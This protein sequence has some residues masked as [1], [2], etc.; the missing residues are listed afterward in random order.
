MKIDKDL[1]RIIVEI[2]DKLGGKSR[3]QFKCEDEYYNEIARL[4]NEDISLLDASKG[5][6]FSLPL[7]NQHKAHSAHAWRMLN[8][9]AIWDY[10]REEASAGML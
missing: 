8:D 3:D 9:M 6:H 4:V 10:H 7:E 2:A 5:K 1:C